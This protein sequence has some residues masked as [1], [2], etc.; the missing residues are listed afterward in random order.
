MN[1]LYIW[2]ED[3]N[4]FRDAEM[5]FDS[6]SRYHFNSK[7]R[8]LSLIENTNP[9]LFPLNNNS[10]IDNISIIVGSNGSGKTSIAALL[11]F[12]MFY[13][14]NDIRYIVIFENNNEKNL[15]TNINEIKT[16]LMFSRNKFNNSFNILYYSPYYNSES[17]FGTFSSNGSTLF[18]DISTSGLME[19]DLEEYKNP[20]TG[21]EYSFQYD[22]DKKT[23]NAILDN[24]RCI[25][26]ISN[27]NA[28]DKTPFQ[29]GITPPQKILFSV[30]QNQLYKY[31]AEC[32]KNSE[33]E[34][35]YSYLSDK[36]NNESYKDFFIERFLLA[37]FCNF[38]TTYLFKDG[39]GIE[40]DIMDVLISN[41][42]KGFNISKEST[43]IIL[44]NIFT[45]IAYPKDSQKI[46][47]NN[48][49]VKA[50]LKLIDFLENL[51]TK[52]FKDEYL[53]FDIHEHKKI[54]DFYNLYKYI[55]GTTG[56]ISSRFFPIL[57]SGE[58]AELLMYSRIMYGISRL[59]VNDSNNKSVLIF[60]DE[61]EITLHPRLQQ[62]LINNMIIF[63]DTFYKN[64][65]YKFHL[66]F[67]THSPILLSDLP[68]SNVIFL[69]KK[70]GSTE[71][72]VKENAK[73]TFASNIYQLF[74]D[75]FFL[76]STPIGDFARKL[77]QSAIDEI[78]ECY[79]KPE[80]SVS[81]KTKQIVSL[82][83]EPVFR[84]LLEDRI[85]K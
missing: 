7:T 80:M 38:A 84:S 83:G 44:Q 35:I 37:M 63:L 82:I 26:F 6:K 19:E 53:V 34:D 71:T 42:K 59:N 69:D 78:N 32:P 67:S 33:L 52:Y 81:E 8:Q 48:E 16:D 70:I 9:I 61:A 75:S 50:R 11:H 74:N 1:L 28:L 24:I 23:A 39:V 72:I 57:S 18:K 65:G 5:N 40:K 13:H 15:M 79:E 30:D 14:G 12:I 60:L 46:I 77:I 49:K 3:F 22:V 47:I 20:K 55:E 29:L 73:Q 17:H 27:Y 4:C 41:I 2:V 45:E 10:S 56:F 76:D 36:L 43:K 68:S 31:E 85:R 51:D 64:M 25:S 58:K 62:R 21:I 66:I 54:A